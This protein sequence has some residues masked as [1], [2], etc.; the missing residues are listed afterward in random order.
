MNKH[1]LLYFCILWNIH[2]QCNKAGQFSL[3]CFT[4]AAQMYF[5]FQFLTF[6][7]FEICLVCF[8]HSCLEETFETNTQFKWEVN[9]I[10]R[11][12]WEVKWTYHALLLLPRCLTVLYLA[13]LWLTVHVFSTIPLSFFSAFRHFA[14][15]L[16]CHIPLRV[17]FFYT[18][19]RSTQKF[20][21]TLFSLVG[22]C[23]R[24]VHKLVPQQFIISHNKVW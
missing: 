14:M 17:Y 16:L 21:N 1:S 20:S 11:Q 12:F 13:S 18:F 24:R 9:K 23:W 4:C 10:F 5:S 22:I 3:V 2:S 15:P 6:I 19:V 8:S 7:S